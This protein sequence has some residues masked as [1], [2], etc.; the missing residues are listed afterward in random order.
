MSMD[1]EKFWADIRVEPVGQGLFRAVLVFG[2]SGEEPLEVP[3]AGEHASE[4]DAIEAARQ[5]IAAMTP[6]GGL[7]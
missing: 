1:D 3:I 2:L 4:A 7:G 6:E 5:A